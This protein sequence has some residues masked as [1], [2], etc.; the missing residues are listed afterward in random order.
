MNY[1]SELLR[2]GTKLCAKCK[3]TKPIIDFP[4]RKGNPIKTCTS[5]MPQY[6]QGGKPERG[7]RRHWTRNNKEKRLA[8]KVVEYAIKRGDLTKQPCEYCG[9]SA[10]KKINA[11]H[12][13]YSQPLKIMWLCTPCHFIRHKEIGRPLGAPKMVP[14]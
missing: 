7:R 2:S 14:A 11:H 13:D 4:H 5:C 1:P 9:A 3:R 8:H 6:K 12:D 10:D